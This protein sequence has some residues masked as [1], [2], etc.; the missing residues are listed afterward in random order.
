MAASEL[1]QHMNLEEEEEIPVSANL[2][3]LWCLHQ[4]LRLHK[5]VNLFPQQQ[6][7]QL[8]YMEA[9]FIAV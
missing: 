5:L 9:E 6:T 4:P 1:Y 3:N 2:C 8:C 7:N